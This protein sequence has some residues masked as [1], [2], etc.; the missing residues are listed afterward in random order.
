MGDAPRIIEALDMSREQL[1]DLDRQW[2]LDP[3]SGQIEPE[4][5]PTELPQAR[6]KPVSVPRQT[7]D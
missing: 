6:P 3:Q 4:I 1:R 2:H 5:D 7:F